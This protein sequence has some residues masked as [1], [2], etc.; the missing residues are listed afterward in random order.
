M[1]FFDAQDQARRSSRRL[2]VAYI[3]ATIAIVLGVTA[4]VG[5]AL[6]NFST[7]DY[8][9]TPGQFIGEQASILLG[10]DVYFNV[11]R[12]S[13]NLKIK[14]PEDL[15]ETLSDKDNVGLFIKPRTPFK[16]GQVS[17]G[18]EAA[19]MGLMEGDRI[20]AVNSKDVEFYDE[21][22]VEKISNINEP[23]EL[24]IDRDGTSEVLTG[25]VPADGIL[26]FMPES[27]LESS[28]EQYGFGQSI[29]KGTDKAFGLDDRT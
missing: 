26:G 24:R 17:K 19:K 4:I 22:E 6:F 9:L 16:V 10:T 11:E 23:I 7:R 2:V 29:V 18:S 21:F 27:L 12:G 14:I 3:V 28:Y 13:E 20:T 25:T 5:I 8:G 1:N 15:I